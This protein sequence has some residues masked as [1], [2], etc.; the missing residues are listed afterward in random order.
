MRLLT[1]VMRSILILFFVCLLGFLIPIKF[2][3]MTYPSSNTKQ[4]FVVVRLDDTKNWWI[5]LGDKNRRLDWDTAPDYPVTIE[6]LQIEDIVCSDL[7][8]AYEPTYFILW[9][10]C[11]VRETLDTEYMVYMR[12][13]IMHCTDWDIL[14]ELSSRN[15]LR[16][17]FCRRYMTIYD[18]KWVDDLRDF[19]D[20]GGILGLIYNGEEK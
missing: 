6:G 20:N 2:C 8:V 3:R 19:I 4:D 5:F 1:Y 10:D 7:Y 16:Q 9:G 11:E 15:S 13:Y 17:K 14:G 18:F 12:E